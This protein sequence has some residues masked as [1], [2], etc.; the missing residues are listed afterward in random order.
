MEYSIQIWLLDKL[1]FRMSAHCTMR[2]ILTG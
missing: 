1:L 2:F